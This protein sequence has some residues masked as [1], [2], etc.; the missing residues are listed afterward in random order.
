MK[1]I[2]LKTERSADLP[3]FLAKKHTIQVVPM[4]V[5]ADGQDYL[6]GHPPVKEIVDYYNRTKK[7]P[8]TTATNTHECQ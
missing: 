3:D 5:I 8:S 7:I 6:D 1:K 2:I 4:H